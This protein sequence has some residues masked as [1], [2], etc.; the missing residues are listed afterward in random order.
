[1]AWAG[2]AIAA[3][4]LVK[5]LPVVLVPALWRERRAPVARRRA[6]ATVVVLYA[7]YAS[8]GLRVFGFLGGY[9]DEEGLGSGT[10]LFAIRLLGSLVPLPR[11]AGAA[12]DGR[13]SRPCSAWSPSAW[14]GSRRTLADPAR[15]CAGSA[16]TRCC[17]P[18]IATVGL[19][20]HYAWYFGWLAFLACL[21]PW[22]CV[23]WLTA[24]CLLLYLDPVHTNLAGTAA[25]Y[26]PFLL[27]ALLDWRRPRRRAVRTVAA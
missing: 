3:A 13:A 15:R 2:V 26:G 17:W 19:T 20:P 14:S 9:A 24:A 18:S 8:V 16:P 23:L 11:W 7:C 12:L 4:T 21:A 25:V 27:L 1:M 10:G 6:L 5:F 22:R